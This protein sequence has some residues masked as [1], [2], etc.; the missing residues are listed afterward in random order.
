MPSLI[1]LGWERDEVHRRIGRALAQLPVDLAIY[2]D[3]K[4]KTPLAAGFER[5]D[6]LLFLSHPEDI[7]KAVEPLLGQGSVLLMAGRIPQ[8]LYHTLSQKLFL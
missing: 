6:G 1:E 2:T 5:K 4:A 3:P 8:R 7:L